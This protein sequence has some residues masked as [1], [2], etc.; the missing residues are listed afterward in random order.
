MKDI[1]NHI[2]SFIV[3]LKIKGIST[4][5]KDNRMI[6]T[7]DG[8]EIVFT[9]SQ[10]QLNDQEY[11]FPYDLIFTSPEKLTSLIQ[12][13]FGLNKRIFA[14][15]CTLQKIDKKTTVDFLNKYHIMNSTGSAY[16]YGLL[17]GEE[18][19][20]VTSFSKGRKM[21][22]LSDDKRSFELIRFCCK[23]GITVTG[24]LT[25][26]I[27]YFCD[28]KNAGDIMTYI[29]KQFSLGESFIKAGFKIY[30]ETEPHY[31]LINKSTFE[32]IPLKN[33]DEVL[34]TSLYYL[35]STAGNIKLVYTPQ[36]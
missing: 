20:A 21:N 12:S 30:S 19:V 33:K 22:R 4:I 10:T 23:E 1:N 34:D 14:R 7:A 36:K 29:D 28:E 18:L 31:F 9:L 2:H 26:M 3:L 25:K 32:R 15:K 11:F 17:Y 6:C 8:K 13:K 27:K 16:N 5:L 24:G 35:L